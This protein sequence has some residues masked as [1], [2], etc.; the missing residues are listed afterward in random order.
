[1]G[2]PG[3]LASLRL[4]AMK[5]IQRGLCGGQAKSIEKR[6]KEVKFKLLLPDGQ[7]PDT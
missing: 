2:K 4:G 1:M 7:T 5:E 6:K 3:S